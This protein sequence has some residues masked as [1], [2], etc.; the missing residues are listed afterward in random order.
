MNIEIDY[1]NE[2]ME[3]TTLVDLISLIT[4]IIDSNPPIVIPTKFE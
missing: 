4:G 2:E 1:E 3:S